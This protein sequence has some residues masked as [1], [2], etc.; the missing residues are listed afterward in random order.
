MCRHKS[1][2]ELV[3]EERRPLVRWNSEGGAQKLRIFLSKLYAIQ[4]FGFARGRI[5]AE[6]VATVE[7]IAG[8]YCKSLET[9]SDTQTYNFFIECASLEGLSPVETVA[10]LENVGISSPT[11]GKEKVYARLASEAVD[12]LVNSYSVESFL[13]DHFPRC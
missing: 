5:P 8:R 9:E 2:A 6:A 13:G 1:D 11:P 7:K 10:I 12:R 3:L 4:E